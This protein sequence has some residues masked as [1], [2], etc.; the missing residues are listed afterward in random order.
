MLTLLIECSYPKDTSWTIKIMSRLNK[1]IDLRIS[2]PMDK[3]SENFLK[4]YIRK[5]YACFRHHSLSI[6]ANDDS[7]FDIEN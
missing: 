4:N 3:I 2:G 1:I 5:A 6:P 7:P